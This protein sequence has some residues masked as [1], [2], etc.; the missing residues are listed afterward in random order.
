MAAA[1]AL[2]LAR[3]DGHRRAGREAGGAAASSRGWS[4]P[5]PTYYRLGEHREQLLELEGFGEISVEQPARGDRGLQAAPVRTRPVRAGDRGGGRGDRAQPRPCASATSTRC[6]DATAEEIAET[7]GIGEKMGASIDGS[8][9]RRAHARADRRPARHR[10]ALRRSGPGRPQAGR[11]RAR[12]SCSPAR[13]PALARA[14]HRAHPGRRRA[15]D[16]RRVEEDRTILVAGEARARSSRRPQRL[17]VRVLDER[18][19]LDLLGDA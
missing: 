10:A 2:R 4:R 1:Q 18:G 16:E 8:A 17:R 13:C 9:A 14:G 15:R 19:L 7:P 12:R 5:P 11:W 6:S 3:R